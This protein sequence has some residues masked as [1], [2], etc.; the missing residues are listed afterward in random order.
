MKALSKVVGVLIVVLFGSVAS[1]GQVFPTRTGG[2]GD[3]NTI[4][5]VPNF[6][7]LV[8]TYDFF[9][10][11]DTMDVYYDG[12][13]IFSSGLISGQGQFTINYGPGSADS[14]MIIMNQG[15]N[16]LTTAWTYQPTVVP[17]PGCLALFGLG[18]PALVYGRRRMLAARGERVGKS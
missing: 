1:Q 17:E 10:I 13:N 3:T 15:G 5:V 8:I 11:P 2:P 16:D 18:V 7:S 14:L 12:A 9:A 4:S 6:G